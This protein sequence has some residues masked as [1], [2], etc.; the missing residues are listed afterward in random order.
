V[1]ARTSYEPP[2]GGAARREV[3]SRL[4]TVGL[5]ASLLLSLVIAVLGR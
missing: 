2:L 4:V 3:A 5:I 1:V